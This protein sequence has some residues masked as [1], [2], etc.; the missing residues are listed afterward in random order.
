MREPRAGDHAGCGDGGHRGKGDV[1]EW[2][3]LGVRKTLFIGVQKRNTSNAASRV[4]PFRGTENFHRR[5]WGFVDSSR[6]EKNRPKSVRKSR[7]TRGQPF[8][9]GA[10]KSCEW[11]RNPPSHDTRRRQCTT[12]SVMSTVPEYNVHSRK[13]EH[14]KVYAV[15]TPRM[16]CPRSSR[17]VAPEM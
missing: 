14:P 9:K 11:A 15:R 5:H 10:R 12:A 1:D 13:K 16:P 3:P 4:S 8:W 7:E 2:R 6:N 17:V